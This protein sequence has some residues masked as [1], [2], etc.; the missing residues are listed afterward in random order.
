MGIGP[1]LLRAPFGLKERTPELEPRRHT[2]FNIQAIVFLGAWFPIWAPTL[3]ILSTP[4]TFNTRARP[5]IVIVIVIN[6]TKYTTG[7]TMRPLRTVSENE[8]E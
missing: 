3:R 2:P 5:G 4:K 8:R 7:V 1:F 6:T